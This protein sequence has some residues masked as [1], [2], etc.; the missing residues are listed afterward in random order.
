MLACGAT[1]R[2]ATP[3]GSNAC[4]MEPGVIYVENIDAAL[5]ALVRLPH[6]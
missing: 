1:E 5:S 2:P 6:L 4:R 3:T